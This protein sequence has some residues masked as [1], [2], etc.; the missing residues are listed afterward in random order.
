MQPGYPFHI[1]KSPALGQ[2]VTHLNTLLSV[3]SSCME[4]KSDAIYIM[5]SNFSVLFISSV[6]LWESPVLIFNGLG[7]WGLF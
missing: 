6:W 5:R 4:I 3:I 1:H 7:D 2:T